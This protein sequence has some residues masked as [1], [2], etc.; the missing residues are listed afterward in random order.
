M[1]LD[2]STSSTLKTRIYQGPTSVVPVSGTE[3]PPIVTDGSDPSI[4]AT[5]RRAGK[6]SVQKSCRPYSARS[7]VA[8]TD[9]GSSGPTGE[10][11]WRATTKDALAIAS[12]FQR[13]V[14]L[15]GP[16]PVPSPL[17]ARVARN[18]DGSATRLKADEFPTV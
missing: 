18:S 11:P 14:T 12:H 6:L 9:A 15:V 17:P 16:E 7:T 1:A 10:A 8:L 4:G 3:W 5:E 13:S 2:P